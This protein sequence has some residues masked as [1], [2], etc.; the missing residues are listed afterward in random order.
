MEVKPASP[1]PIAALNSKNP[2]K[3]CRKKLHV[4]YV[5]GVQSSKSIDK[6]HLIF[7]ILLRRN[8][9]I[10]WCKNYLKIPSLGIYV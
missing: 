3:D 8:L 2:T 9:Q 7:L 6:E 10:I 1:K 4:V 5:V